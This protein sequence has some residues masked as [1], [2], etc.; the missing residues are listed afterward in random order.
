VVTEHGVAR[1]WGTSQTEQ[2][3]TLIEQ[4]AHPRVREELW[5]EAGA[6]GLT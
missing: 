2:A 5:E 3:A 4:A 1:L 6:L